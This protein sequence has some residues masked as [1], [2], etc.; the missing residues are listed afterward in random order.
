MVDRKNLQY[1]KLFKMLLIGDSG[2]GKSALLLKFTDNSFT[3]QYMSTI[4][5]D[6]K[7][8]TVKIEDLT[9]KLQIWD[10]AGQERFRTITSSYYRG[11]HGIF[12]VYDVTNR[13]SFESAPQLWMAELERYAQEGVA[14]M[15][16]GTKT[17]LTESRA[18]STS[19]GR[20]LAA[21]CNSLFL[22]TSAKSGEGVEE[23]FL[24]LAQEIN[25]H[26]ESNPSSGDKTKLDL[27]S[28]K[29]K[30]RGLCTL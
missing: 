12:V 18:V 7:I 11:A 5:V 25:E 30:R 6:F 1:D 4:G 21:K 10:T 29:N 17:D 2:V 3:D 15:L 9:I 27:G 13:E 26:D 20:D 28:V 14:K 22:E 8:K 24:K 23:A 19:E 16:I